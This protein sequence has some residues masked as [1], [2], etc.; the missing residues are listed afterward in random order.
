MSFQSKDEQVLAQQLKVQEL[1]VRFADG[2]LYS[3]T[4][5][6]VVDL[7][8]NCSVA[9]V[10]H[11]DSSV[12]AVSLGAA[13]VTGSSA[14]IALAAPFAAGDALIIKYVVAE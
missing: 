3:G 4:S 9:S 6:V 1:V 8:E 13:T 12:P 10:L 2:A 5:P 11:C 7:K 14:S